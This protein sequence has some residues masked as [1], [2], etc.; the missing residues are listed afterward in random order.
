V[1]F[2]VVV[3]VSICLCLSFFPSLGSVFFS[4]QGGDANM[5]NRYGRVVDDDRENIGYAG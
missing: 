1:V 3:G 4:T 2:S 5:V